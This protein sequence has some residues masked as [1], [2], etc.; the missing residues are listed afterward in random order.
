MLRN[1]FFVGIE[2]VPVQIQI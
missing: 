1:H 2:L